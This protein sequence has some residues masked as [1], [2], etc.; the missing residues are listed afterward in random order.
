M[1]LVVIIENSTPDRLTLAVHDADGQPGDSG[2]AVTFHFGDDAFASWEHW[3][4]ADPHYHED[5]ELR[6]VIVPLAAFDAW[7]V[8]T[9]RE[10]F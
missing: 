3:T 6:A 7:I 8:N 2:L 10:A 4:V 1:R 9:I 5:P